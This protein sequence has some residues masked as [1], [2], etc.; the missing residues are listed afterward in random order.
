MI[1]PLQ[2]PE[3]EVVRPHECVLLPIVVAGDLAV[4]TP[5]IEEMSMKRRQLFAM[6]AVLAV[7]AVL[8]AADSRVGTWKY[9][10]AKS[11][12]DPP[13][14]AYKS[15][16]AKV[17][18][19]GEGIK[20]AVE[21]VGSD[22]KPQAYSYNVNYDGKDY[23]VTG[24]P[25]YDAV[26]YKKVDENTLEGTNKKGGQVVSTVTIAVSKDGKTMTVTSK[27]KTDKGAFNNVVVYD[28]Q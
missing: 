6:L 13:S 5:Q 25:M 12:F 1:G 2:R 24:I 23:P 18:A 26:A 14:G 20:V 10:A 8:L 7:P 4:H 17:E 16:T 22:D 9:N 27:G 3:T 11:K 19:A 28:K 21:G 15:R